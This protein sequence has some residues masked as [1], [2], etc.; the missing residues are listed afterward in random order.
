MIRNRVRRRL[1]EVVRQ[2]LPRVAPGWDVVLIART[3]IAQATYHD[4]EQACERLLMQSTV[5]VTPIAAMSEGA[6]RR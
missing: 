4:I 5:L 6:Q 1:R 2:R 3:P